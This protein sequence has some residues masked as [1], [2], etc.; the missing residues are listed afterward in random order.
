VKLC[1]WSGTAHI[2]AAADGVANPLLETIPPRGRVPR[3]VGDDA[4]GND[5]GVD[6]EDGGVLTA[7]FIPL[8]A[9]SGERRSLGALR[10][11]GGGP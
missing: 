6:V 9:Q 8:A 1:R 7:S 4:Q 3:G 10:T 5:G 2:V 11:S